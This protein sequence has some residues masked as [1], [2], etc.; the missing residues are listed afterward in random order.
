ME[1]DRGGVAGGCFGDSVC[2]KERTKYELN[3]IE[4]TET[5]VAKMDH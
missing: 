2:R 1:E 3:R 5:K 4:T